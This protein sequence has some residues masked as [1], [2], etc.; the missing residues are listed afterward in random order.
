MPNRILKESICASPN[1]NQLS[2]RAEAFF[3]RL[4]VNSD[5]YGKFDGRLSIIIARCYPLRI[6]ETTEDDIVNLLIELSNA[7]LI[8]IYKKEDNHFIQISTWDKHQQIRAKKSKY[9]AIDSTCIQLIANDFRKQLIAN[10]FNE[11]NDSAQA[12]IME[13]G[14]Q[15]IANDSKCPRNPIQYESNPIQSPRKD[16]SDKLREM[17]KIYEQEIGDITTP[18]I[19]DK[20]RTVEDEYSLE[21]FK[22]GLQKAVIGQ[23]RNLNYAI[24]IMKDYKAN[25]IPSGNGK[26]PQ[27]QVKNIGSDGWENSL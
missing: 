27:A 6:K 11:K 10:D 9:P 20:I 26:K 21:I 1:I 14:K 8:A 15:L 18:M 12:Q 3:Y 5:D 2:D 19:A 25:G 22:A 24:E 17:C 13:N 4:I 7:S 16:F 23:H